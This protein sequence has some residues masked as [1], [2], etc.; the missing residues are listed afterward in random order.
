VVFASDTDPWMSA[1]SAQ[2]W[3]R[4]WGS[5]FVNLG[6]VGHI[7]TEAGFGPLPRALYHTQALIRRIE[8]SR[9]VSRAH[10]QEFSFSV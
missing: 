7:N 2:R 8:Q 3:A 10:V 5:G 6:D 1:Y 9:R 4:R